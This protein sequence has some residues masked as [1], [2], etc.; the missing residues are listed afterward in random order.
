MEL[1][2]GWQEGK[3]APVVAFLERKLDGLAFTGLTR[4][5]EKAATARPPHEDLAQRLAHGRLI[6]L[7]RRMNLLR[8]LD[9]IFALSESD[10]LQEVHAASV[11][12]GHSPQ[13]IE[14]QRAQQDDTLSSSV[15]HPLLAQR[16][17]VV[18]NT[19]GI[20]AITQQAAGGRAPS[21]S[22]VTP[23]DPSRPFAEYLMSAYQ[24]Q[25]APSQSVQVQGELL[26][27]AHDAIIIHRPDD[28][29]LVWNQGA[30]ALYGW[31]EQ[32]AIG[33]NVHTLLRTRFY[34]SR[35]AVALVLATRRHWQ[36]QLTQTSRG[37]KRLIVDSHQIFVPAKAGQ[38][39][40]IVEMNQDITEREQSRTSRSE[41]T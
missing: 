15:L 34:A 6:L 37:G 3:T 28:R 13:Q 22:V 12:Y 35:E 32:E 38:A 27:Q 14:Q 20:H 9:A 17:M 1:L 24:E 36:G 21:W 39:A 2:R 30:V 10:L 40:V 26:A 5:I 8:A 23:T 19:L 41:G 11:H 25:T 4:K 31:T 29:I 18:M 16:N 7:N 33:K